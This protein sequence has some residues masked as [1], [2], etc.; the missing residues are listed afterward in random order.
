M[1]NLV[2]EFLAVVDEFAPQAALAADHLVMVFCRHSGERI[3]K[4][5]LG[6]REKFASR[7]TAILIGVSRQALGK[8]E[9]GVFSGRDDYFM[10]SFR[11]FCGILLVAP[12]LDDRAGRKFSPGEN[13]VPAD[14][15]LAPARDGTSGKSTTTA[16]IFHILET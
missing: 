3:E 11:R 5:H 4:A 16:M 8:G 15:P 6:G 12:A 14:R 1:Q 7:P 10:T 9:I 13:L 2:V